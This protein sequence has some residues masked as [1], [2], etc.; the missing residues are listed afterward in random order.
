VQKP[1]P[2]PPSLDTLLL[3]SEDGRTLNDAAYWLI[4]GGQYDRAVPL[5][6]KAIRYTSKSSVIHGYATFNLGLSLLK[7][8]RCREALPYLQTALRIEAPGQRHLI[9]PRIKQ[10]KTCVR[11]GAAGQAQSP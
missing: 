2:A 1:P 8:G 7:T 10:A 11:R 5:A 4:R 3:Q 6:Q 9:R